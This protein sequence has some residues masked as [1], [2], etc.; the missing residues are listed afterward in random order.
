MHWEFLSGS[1][2]FLHGC[3]HEPLTSFEVMANEI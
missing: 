2:Q 1:Y 3:G